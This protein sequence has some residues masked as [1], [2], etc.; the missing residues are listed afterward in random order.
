[1]KYQPRYQ[2]TAT[3]VIVNLDSN[4]KKNASK[5]YT[6]LGSVLSGDAGTIPYGVDRN[7]PALLMTRLK[8]EVDPQGG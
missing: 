5:N 8:G 1:M 3:L 2:N 7:Y 6:Q 4:L